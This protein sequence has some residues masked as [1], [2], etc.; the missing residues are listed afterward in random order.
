MQ[1][2]SFLGA[3]GAAVLAPLARPARAAQGTVLRFVPQSNLSSIDPVW[4]TANVSR[5]HGY[6]VYDTLY[7]SDRAYAPQPQLAAG[8]LVEEDGRR[9]VI[10]LRE[11]IRFHD[12][13]PIRARDAVASIRRW[14]RRNAFGQKLLAATE[15]LSALDDRRL[16]F[17][18]RKP[19]PLLAH[20]L[21]F[22]G[23]PAF[24]MPERVAETDPFRQIQDATGSGPY[25]FLADEYN[26]GSLAAY[27][28]F[29]GY[30]PITAGTP[31]LTA[32]P[33][34]AHFDRIEWRIINDGGTASA[35]L[36]S[37]EIDWFEMPEYELLELF[38]RDR[39]LSVEVLDTGGNN[40]FLRLNHLHPPFNNKAVRQALLH[41]VSQADFMAANAGPDRAHWRDDTGVFTPGSPSASRA[42]LEPLL[43]PRSLE[44]ARSLLKEAGYDGQLTRIL[45][46]TDIPAA[47]AWSQVAADLFRRLGFNL[48]YATSDWGTVLQ[49]RA[50]Q[51]AVEKGGWS[52]ITSGFS[53]F[54]FASP[55]SHPLVR[56]NGSQGWFGWPD[57]PKL[58][59]LRDAWF[60]AADEASRKA[61]A[62][63]IQRTVIDEVA[64]IP[65]GT[66]YFRTALRRTLRDR[67]EGLPIFWNIRRA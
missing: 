8:H 45:G 61:I 42:G 30:R 34:V 23:Q 51:E 4:T 5:N 48:D 39:N 55:A 27:A 40:G 19:F 65:T 32:G 63:D 54:D 58:E 35:A 66:Y 6:L 59:E 53:S 31:S 37:G 57:I 25:R 15:E 52:A 60:E 20:A 50:S 56:G 22:A 28:R 33:K 46:P 36:Q 13:E 64:Y 41:A 3:A 24:I 67:V 26:S 2:R 16:Q 18:L 11:G 7:G 17:R 9:W 10:T 47:S 21:A 62:E 29:D 12:G 49:R 43:T 44:K 38:A 1:R 14:G